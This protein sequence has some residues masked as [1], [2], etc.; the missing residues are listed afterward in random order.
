MADE[1]KKEEAPVKKKS[2]T[3]LIIIIGVVLLLISVALVVFVIFPKYQEMTGNGTNQDT[4]EAKDQDE[5]QPVIGQIFKI[6]NITINPKGS[7]GRRF[8]V[9]EVALEYHNPELANELTTMEPI[10][11]DRFIKYLR[12]KTVLELT[13]EDEME[14]IRKKMKEIVNKT[15]KK[16]NAIT[17]IFFTRYV[18]E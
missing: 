3:M 18:L 6:S 15:L 10:I 1:E 2:K 8:A 16:E 13:Q 5:Q 4:V 17:N 7:L 11:M 12:T 14:K 9:F